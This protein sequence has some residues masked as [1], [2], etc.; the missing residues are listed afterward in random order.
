MLSCSTDDW[1]AIVKRAVSDAKNGNVKA[2]E[3]LAG[4]LL[5]IPDS[6]A[7]SL[8][9]LAVDEEAGVDRVLQ[10]AAMSKLGLDT[11]GSRQS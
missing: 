3:W 5:G 10:E 11:V 1:A 9:R 7:P 8:F 2:R 4:Y 6:R